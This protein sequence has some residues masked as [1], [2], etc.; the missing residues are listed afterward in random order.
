MEHVL[1]RNSTSCT[2][3]SRACAVKQSHN[4]SAALSVPVGASNEAVRGTS[5]LL[6]LLCCTSGLLLGSLAPVANGQ[7]STACMQ[8][9]H[10]T[11]LAGLQ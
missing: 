7:V 5:L 2:A 3:G 4:A 1:Q 6:D 9:E 11:T 8:V 10:S